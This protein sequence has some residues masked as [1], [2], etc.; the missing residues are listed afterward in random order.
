MSAVEN[1]NHKVMN[2]P[3]SSLVKSHRVHAAARN[4][5][6]N[7]SAFSLKFKICS[8]LRRT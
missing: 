5:F 3:S 8:V 7:A 1:T 4:D 6:C 2:L